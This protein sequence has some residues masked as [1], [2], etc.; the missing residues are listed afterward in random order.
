MGKNTSRKAGFGV[1]AVWFGSH[2]G[3][4]FATGTL[5]AN[6]YVKYGAWAII[7]PLIALAI[8]CIVGTIQWEV[9]RSNKV[10]DY[11][12][13]GDVLYRPQ[14]KIWCTVFEIMFVVDVI[15]A[16]GI[17]YASAGNLIQGWI[18]MPYILATAIFTV[19]I[20]LLTMFGS[21]FLLKIGTLLSVVLVG[22]LIITSVSGIASGK[23]TLTRIV[24]NWEVSAGF[25]TALWSAILYASFQCACIATTHSL[26]ESLPDRKSSIWA[27][28]FGFIL[29]G[30]MMLLTALCL[31]SHYPEMVTHKLPTFDIISAL[32]MPWLRVA[33]SLALFLA[34]V[35]TGITC[36]SSLSIRLEK[37]TA[38][39][40]K[41]LTVCRA[42]SSAVV[43][44]VAFLVAQIGLL[45]ILN[46]G[47]SFIGYI[48]IPLV[49]L[50]TV[51]LGVKRW[52]TDE[53]S[54][55]N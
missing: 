4:G 24:T 5:A 20:V 6:Y 22:C 27:G 26:C 10:Y 42:V 40:Y 18:P 38:H 15:M 33:Y 12:S 53:T 17:V 13:F 3:G 44:I 55:T 47:Y 50:P 2:C 49:I 41:N 8:M 7:M 16:L 51:I 28:I 34:L 43:M 48:C 31:L 11:K 52:K 14:Q 19:I 46:K 29:N 1:A 25:G 39:K 9:C 30:A 35:T 36:A 21:K 37:L 54:T 32:N 45:A 23:E